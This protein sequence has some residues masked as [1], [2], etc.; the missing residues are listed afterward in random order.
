MDLAQS[1]QKLFECYNTIFISQYEI[2][3][4]YESEKEKS[5]TEQMVSMKE[6]QKSL[7]QREFE[8]KNKNDSI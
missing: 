3:G 1:L 7:D 4:A 8:L 5:F 6:Q 2:F